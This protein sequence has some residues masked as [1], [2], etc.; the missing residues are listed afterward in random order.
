MVYVQN[1]ILFCV[2][3]RPLRKAAVLINYI[4]NGGEFFFQ[5]SGMQKRK[6]QTIFSLK[7]SF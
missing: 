5:N 3:P 7:I 4:N 2:L 6:H 1:N